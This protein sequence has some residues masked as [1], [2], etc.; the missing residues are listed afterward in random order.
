M[1]RGAWR[2]T[3]HGVAKSQTRLKGQHARTHTVSSHFVGIEG[4]LAGEGDLPL[5]GC[6]R[7]VREQRGL[8]AFLVSSAQAFPV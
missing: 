4:S 5:P 7:L 6:R 3:V 8:R 1:D 2:D